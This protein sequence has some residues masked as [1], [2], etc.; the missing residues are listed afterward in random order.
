MSLIQTHKIA[1]GT[2]NLKLK[3]ELEVTARCEAKSGNVIVVRALDEKTVYDVLELDTGRMAKIMRGD[4]IVGALGDRRALRG[5]VGHVPDAIRPNDRLHILNLGGVIGECTSSN[6]DLGAPLQVEVIGMV[7]HN[8]GYL[9]IVEGALPPVQTWEND[10]PLVLVSGT[11][12]NSGKT[13]ALCEVIRGLSERG[14]KVVGAKITGVACQK[15]LLNMEDHGAIATLSFVD[16][17]YASTVGVPDIA[18]I[19]RTLIGHL[20]KYKPDLAVVELGDGIIGG[21]RV[22]T[23]FDDEKFMSQVKCHLMAANDL[24]AAWGALELC[25]QRQVRVD[26]VT[27]PATDNE[28]G[29]NHIKDVFGVPAAN[30][31]MNPEKLA[32]IVQQEVA[33]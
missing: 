32:G 10:I 22:D 27:G 3:K 23:V 7:A 13:L 29:L 16:C 26:L 33:L 28:V 20:A 14:F 12:M 1:S 8:D 6:I 15:D 5:F 21:Y 11:C 30:A 2:K 18:G 9:N 4:I 24:V 19:A 25:K 17:G 31:R